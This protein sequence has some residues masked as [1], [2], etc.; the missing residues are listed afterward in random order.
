M[1]QALNQIGGRIMKYTQGPW[2][3]RLI[4]LYNEGENNFVIDASG[5]EVA[6]TTD[7]DIE[8]QEA[9]ARLIAAAPEML[10]ALEY[11]LPIMRRYSEVDLDVEGIGAWQLMKAAITG[12]KEKE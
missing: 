3:A 8:T 2:K 12:A 1:V 4:D 11:T 5:F 9:N 10:E 6:V 7:G